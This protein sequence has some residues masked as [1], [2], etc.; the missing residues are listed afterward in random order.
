VDDTGFIYLLRKY[1]SS[2]N[3][4]VLEL[5]NGFIENEEENIETLLQ[6][7]L[8]DQLGL[9]SEKFEPF[10]DFYL[11]SEISNCRIL[12]YKNSGN[13]SVMDFS[14]IVSDSKDTK[15]V[16]KS[17]IQLK[18][19]I[20]NGNIRDSISL[21]ALSQFVICEETRIFDGEYSSKKTKIGLTSLSIGLAF[22]FI[23]AF[24]FNAQF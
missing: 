17:I 14:K 15:I 10:R 12:I 1:R 9:Y 20:F 16:K 23:V 22:G 8:S 4:N 24:L 5:P 7:I 18:N 19:D 6:K 2:V 3:E 13:L 21:S 11:N